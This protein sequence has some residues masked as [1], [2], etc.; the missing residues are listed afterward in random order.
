[1]ES[2]L[3]AMKVNNSIKEQHPVIANRRTTFMKGTHI[4]TYSIMVIL[5]LII[6]PSTDIVTQ[7]EKFAVALRKKKKE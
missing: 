2:N 1:M 4:Q 6:V 5:T 3:I 7:R